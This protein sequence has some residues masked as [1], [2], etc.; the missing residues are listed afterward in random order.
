MVNPSAGHILFCCGCDFV[1]Y[2]RG[3]GQKTFFDVFR[4]NSSFIV[5]DGECSDIYCHSGLMSFY[6]LILLSS[7]TL[8]LIMKTP[9][10]TL[11]VQIESL[12]IRHHLNF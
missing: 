3:F 12:W 1:S 10:T 4:K 9:T 8:A 11:Q 7:V 6:R 2:F 5:G